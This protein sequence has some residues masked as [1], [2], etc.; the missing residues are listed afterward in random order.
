MGSCRPLVLGTQS[1]QSHTGADRSPDHLATIVTWPRVGEHMEG[2]CVHTRH[3]QLLLSL[4]LKRNRCR[5][6]NNQPKCEVAHHQTFQVV[7]G[8][9]GRG[10]AMRSAV[11][12]HRRAGSKKTGADQLSTP[13]SRLMHQSTAEL[14]PVSCI[15]PTEAFVHFKSQPRM[16]GKPLETANDYLPKLMHPPVRIRVSLLKQK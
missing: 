5:N 3:V 2:F 6:S 14:Q 10:S 12:A 16:P 9:A 15:P 8:V 1:P 11:P 13:F 7:S 4:L